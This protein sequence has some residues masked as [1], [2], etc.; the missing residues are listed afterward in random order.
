MIEEGR[1]STVCSQ[2]IQVTTHIPR[3]LLGRAEIT[4]APRRVHELG[5]CCSLL[6]LNASIVFDPAIV[7]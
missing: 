1:V 2:S 5:T 6:Y 4:T 3:G 7:T